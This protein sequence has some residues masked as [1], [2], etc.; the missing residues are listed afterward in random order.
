M[1]TGFRTRSYANKRPSSG[2]LPRQFGADKTKSDKGRVAQRKS[3]SLTWRGSQVR[4]LS[5]PPSF[6]PEIFHP[7]AGAMAHPRRWFIALIALLVI[8]GGAAAAWAFDGVISAEALVARVASLGVWAPVGFV[9]LYG[10]ATIIMVPG[11]IFDLAGGA[12]FG[13]YLGSALNLTGGS[14]G[15]ALAFLVGRYLARDWV[16][17]RAC[18]LY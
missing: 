11:S 14:L 2:G 12:L 3:T 17:A 10:V 8:G 6:W 9:L 1:G 16:E 18:L 15:A 5:R 7:P 4:S 13:P